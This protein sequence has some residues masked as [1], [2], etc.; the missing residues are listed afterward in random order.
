MS[1]PSGSGSRRRQAS[2]TASKPFRS[3]IPLG[4]TTVRMADIP[5]LRNGAVPFA[6]YDRTKEAY[7]VGGYCT[8]RFHS[9]AR[10]SPRHSRFPPSSVVG[11]RKRWSWHR[12]KA[13]VGLGPRSGVIAMTS[14]G[15][16]ILIC[17]ETVQRK[18]LKTRKHSGSPSADDQHRTEPVGVVRIEAEALL[19]QFDY[20]LW[21]ESGN[22]SDLFI[23]Y[24]DNGCGKT[25]ILRVLFHLLSAGNT[26]GHRSAIKDIPFKRFEVFLA[27]GTRLKLSRDQPISGPYAIFAQRPNKTPIELIFGNVKGRE[28]RFAT[29]ED[30]VS[31]VGFVEAL[32]LT[33]YF[34][35]ADRRIK[36]DSLDGEDDTAGKQLLLFPDELIINKRRTLVEDDA[37]EQTR[38]VLHAMSLASSWIAGQVL[39]AVNK[40]SSSS[41]GIYQE[42]V[43]HV[44][45]GSR[46]FSQPVQTDQVIDTLRSLAVRSSDYARFGF[47]PPLSVDE[48]ID[49]V[50]LSTPDTIGMI[51]EILTP[52]IRGTEA[53]LNVLKGI[54]ALTEQF[55]HNLDSFLLRKTISFSLH[56]GLTINLQD[57]TPLKPSWLSSGEKHLLV[58]FCH[59]LISNDKRCIFI[60][61]EPE[62]SLNVKWQRKLITSLLQIIGKSQVQFIMATHAI[63]L[64]AEHNQNVVK[65]VPSPPAAITSPLPES[66]LIMIEEHD[67]DDPADN[68]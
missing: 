31:F 42:I 62:L 46:D 5:H 27:D 39:Q 54:H 48:M 1:R 59:V 57:G 20:L 64:L 3:P 41:H 12:G 68:P 16:L 32:G 36:S 6:P 25:T 23:L 21:S 66:K 65:L 60:I 34:L 4:P 43:K 19:G 9:L 53:R 44:L 22:L 11:M 35:S 37:D 18:R 63:E 8:T 30:E 51:N 2:K 67:S 33:V 15:L 7:H 56:E 52:Y 26:R 10:S 49:S 45:S 47:I 61:D 40:G 28:R 13:L 29:T 14:A 50:K 24:G 38:A 58:L 55:I 17:V